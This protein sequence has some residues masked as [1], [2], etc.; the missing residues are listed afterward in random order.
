M[1]TIT[2]WCLGRP[3]MLGKTVRGASSR[4]NPAFTIP[5]PLSHTMAEISPSSAI[6]IHELRPAFT[7]ERSVPSGSALSD[8][9]SI[10]VLLPFTRAGRFQL[11]VFSV[12]R[13]DPLFDRISFRVSFCSLGHS[14]LSSKHRLVHDRFAPIPRGRSPGTRLV[15]S[16]SRSMGCVV[17][18]ACAWFQRLVLRTRACVSSTLSSL[19]VFDWSCVDVDLVSSR[20]M[21]Y[22]SSTS[23]PTSHVAPVLLTHAFFPPRVRVSL[24]WC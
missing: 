14:S 15:Q 9:I 13:M 16:W 23:P 24:W 19:C 4:A 6:S 11:G 18:H 20:V 1:P 22:D 10:A 17:D 21:P 12:W 5:E 8:V 3:M 2:P 7:T